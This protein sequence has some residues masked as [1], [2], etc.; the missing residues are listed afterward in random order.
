VPFDRILLLGTF[1]G[2]GVHADPPARRVTGYPLAAGERLPVEQTIA[3]AAKFHEPGERLL[4][5]THHDLL[6]PECSVLFG[7]ADPRAN[8]AIV[9]SFH[10]RADG[11]RVR[12]PRRL[13]NEIAH[14]LG[15]LQ[16]L[17]HCGQRGCLMRPVAQA[18]EL[19]V[20]S[21]EPCGRCPQTLKRRLRERLFRHV[22]A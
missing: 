18:A 11:D 6:L 12:W 21:S 17:K 1:D 8:V 2:S 4:I 22:E 14:E 20:R 3:W 13:Q 10:L 15:H 5:L 16:G 7:F 19:D 9:S